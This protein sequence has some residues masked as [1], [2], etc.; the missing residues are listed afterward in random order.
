MIPEFARLYATEAASSRCSV[1]CG[2][3]ARLAPV[4][5]SIGA[6]PGRADSVRWLG[7]AMAV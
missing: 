7:H 1:A 3:R 6:I 4:L 2:R 5:N